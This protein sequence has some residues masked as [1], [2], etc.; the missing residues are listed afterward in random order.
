M[1]QTYNDWEVKREGVCVQL[2]HRPQKRKKRIRE[3]S[4]LYYV[5]NILMAAFILLICYCWYCMIWA[6]ME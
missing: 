3:G 2:E 6:L 4:I 1:T 5:K